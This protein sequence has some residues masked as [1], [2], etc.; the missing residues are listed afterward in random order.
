MRHRRIVVVDLE[1]DRMAISFE[2]PKVMLLVRIVG[3]AEIVVNFDCLDD[4]RDCLRA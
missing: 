2:G 4:T 3:V 1:K